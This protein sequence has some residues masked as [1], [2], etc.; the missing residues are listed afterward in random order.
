MAQ[1]TSRA[2]KR[3]TV[4]G[5]VELLQQSARRDT[6]EFL[7]LLQ[8]AL[9]DRRPTVRDKAVL[10]VTE[11]KI[12]EAARLVE[13]LLSD[14]NDD[15]RYDAAECIGIIERGRKSSPPGLYD[16]LG[17]KRALVRAQAA[18]SVALLEDQRALPKV[19][20]LLSDEDPVVR[21][22]AASTVGTLGGFAY[23]KNI[24]R[25]LVREKHELARV[26]LY[27]ALFL[28]GEREAF[29]EMLKLLQ[30]SDYHV[31]CSVAN[32]LEVMPLAAS[33]VELAITALVGA[34]RKPCA[35]ADQTTTR[36]VLK[37]LR[38]L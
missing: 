24:R 5:Q 26:G 28:L 23:L 31:R 22:Y 25:G 2:T 20:R 29:P 15:V 1:K 13:P 21:S 10:I 30:S 32:T 18:E 16:L 7:K 9:S 11:H 6:K 34:S 33:E 27:E 35:V 37:A 38:N 14:N 12:K 3:Q 17:D 4:N 8:T 36:R 19:V